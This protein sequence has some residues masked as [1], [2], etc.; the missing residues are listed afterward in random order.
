MVA[1]TTATTVAS[2]DRWKLP[3]PEWKAPS[4]PS[5]A[6]TGGG[7]APG[8]LVRSFRPETMNVPRIPDFSTAALLWVT[9]VNNSGG[10]FW[11]NRKT[12]TNEDPK[13]KQWNMLDHWYLVG[14]ISSKHQ[15]N[16]LWI[17]IYHDCFQA[18]SH[19]GKLFTSLLNLTQA[20]CQEVDWCLTVCTTKIDDQ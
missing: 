14:L 12:W 7:D 11:W 17:W 8:P 15:G 10:W 4:H 5:P 1:A 6:E 16:G 18:F 2:P 13:K 19:T 3:T 20:S 9:S